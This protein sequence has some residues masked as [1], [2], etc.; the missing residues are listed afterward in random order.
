MGAL[1]NSYKAAKTLP[2]LKRQNLIEKLEE[3]GIRASKEGKDIHD[4]TDKELAFELVIS[5]F[6]ERD[7][8]H[9]ENAMF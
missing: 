1:L 3:K 5:N 7:I 4:M 8:D 2:E 6:K 9:S